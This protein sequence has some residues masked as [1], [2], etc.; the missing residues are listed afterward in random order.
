M[1]DWMQLM[2][3]PVSN[4]KTMTPWFILTQFGL[5][6]ASKMR[7][8]F[9]FSTMQ[10]RD[11]AQDWTVHVRMNKKV[12]VILNQPCYNINFKSVIQVKMGK[13]KGALLLLCN[14]GRQHIF[15][16]S[17]VTFAVLTKLILNETSTYQYY[18]IIT[19]H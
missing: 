3:H 14:R 4:G 2:F 16:P 13:H 1:A 15:F 19:G 6:I 7:V 12:A 18:W 11:L 8:C 9:F 5:Q 10:C 17:R